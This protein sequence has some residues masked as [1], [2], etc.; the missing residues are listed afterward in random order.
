MRP[1]KERWILRQVLWISRSCSSG[2]P[3]HI[4]EGLFLARTHMKSYYNEPPIAAFEKEP[5]CSSFP[6]S[7]R[8]LAADWF[9]GWKFEVI[10]MR[11]LDLL[12]SKKEP[13]NQV[14][15]CSKS[16]G[17]PRINICSYGTFIPKYLWSWVSRDMI[18]SLI[19][20]FQ[21][22]SQWVLLK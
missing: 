18:L 8:R 12:V 7:S 11:S 19:L 2:R 9:S 13:Q 22:A 1:T 6:G 15:G 14:I 3:Y 10:F 20:L 16:P 17:S 4:F 5:R 21:E